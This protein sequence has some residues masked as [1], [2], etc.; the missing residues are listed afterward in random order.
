MAN[1]AP[2]ACRP[3]SDEDVRTSLDGILARYGHHSRREL[4]LRVPRWSE[5]AAFVADL[6]RKMVGTESPAEANRRQRRLYAEEL[7]RSRQLLT[8]RRRKRFEKKLIRLRRYLWLREQMRDLSLKLYSN[9]RK[10]TIEIGRRAAE[11]G[12][13]ESPDDAFYLTFR[14]MD[15]VLREPCA[16]LVE[17][18]RQYELMYRNFRAPTRSAAASPSRRSRP[19]AGACPGSVA[20]RASSRACARVVMM[21]E[22]AE[23]LRPGE[24]LV[25]PY[26]DPGWTPLLNVAA[27]VIT[28]NGGLLSHA[29]VICRELAIPAVLNVGSAT[30]LLRHD[31]L[32]RLDGGQ[33]YVDI[34]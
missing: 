10:H 29:A 1:P 16:D 31:Q 11:A 4:D 34:V 9:I 17:S 22:E 12:D 6:A 19:P 26:T 18:R 2:S 13:L 5:D 15:R 25:C 27:G 28:E 33:G 32:V 21:L 23:K 3:E 8:P 14:E 24:I 20:A 7:E 30:R